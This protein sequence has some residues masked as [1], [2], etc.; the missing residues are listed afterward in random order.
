MLNSGKMQSK[1]DVQSAFKNLVSE[2]DA[3]LKMFHFNN[4][5]KRK[6]T[7]PNPSPLNRNGF[8]IND[9]FFKESHR[10]SEKKDNSGNLSIFSNKVKTHKENES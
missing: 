3:K 2:Q 8:V 5:L 1:S 4:Q 10:R 9:N 7:N 6:N